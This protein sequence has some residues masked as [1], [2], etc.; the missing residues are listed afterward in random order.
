MAK[1]GFVGF[2]FRKFGKVR[3]SSTRNGLKDWIA[4]DSAAR[5]PKHQHYVERQ[6]STGGVEGLDGPPVNRADLE[7][8]CEMAEV[9]YSVAPIWLRCESGKGPR[10]L[11]LPPS[12]V[13]PPPGICKAMV[14][15][16]VLDRT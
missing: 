5:W 15:S 13:F 12:P 10:S 14:E 4:A 7:A 16:S 11:V 8:A 3:P 6:H 2:H 9:K 1:P